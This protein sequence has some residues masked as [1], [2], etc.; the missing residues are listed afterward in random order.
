MRTCDK[1]D[2]RLVGGF[3]AFPKKLLH[4]CPVKTGQEFFEIVE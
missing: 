3:Y 4:C 1:S 2:E